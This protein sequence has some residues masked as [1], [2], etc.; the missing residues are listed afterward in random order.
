MTKL[1]L[2]LAVGNYDRTRALVDG[3]VQID[4]VDPVVH[5]LSP[6]EI[7]F[8]AFRSEDFDICEL[9]M[10]SFTVKTAQG[11]SPYVGIPAFLS[12]AFRHTSIVVR[13]DRIAAPADLKGKRIGVP[14][15]QLTACVW[16]RAILAEQGVLPEDVIWV[17][18]GL[19]ELGRPEKITI[20]FPSS[21]KIESAPGDKSLSQMLAAGEIDAVI[22]PRLPSCFGADATVGWLY[23]DPIAEASAWFE[24]TGIFPIMHIVGIRRALVDEHPWLPMSVFKALNSAKAVALDE[25]TDTSATKVTLPFVEEQLARA[26]ALMGRDFWSYGLQENLPTLIAFLEAH[27]KQGLSSRLVSPEELFHPS[28]FEAYKI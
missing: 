4:G 18:G 10:S 3:R 11:A 20:S 13:R 8:R 23:D 1:R 28:T 6:E 16:A 2:S 24:R 25:L 19:E 17:R 14:E 21:V 9:S 26:R 12:R 5:L 22:A 27:H 7:F 15:Y